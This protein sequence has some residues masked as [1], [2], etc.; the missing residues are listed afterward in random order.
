MSED[1]EVTLE[2]GVKDGT[3]QGVMK[4][5]S[6]RKQKKFD[7]KQRKI[8]KKQTKLDNK[9]GAVKKITKH[10]QKKFDRKQRKIDRKQRKLNK[11]GVRWS[12]LP[13]DVLPEKKYNNFKEFVSYMKDKLYIKN[14]KLRAFVKVACAVLA[15]VIVAGVITSASRASAQKKWLEDTYARLNILNSKINTLVVAL[16]GEPMNE[17]DTEAIQRKLDRIIKLLEEKGSGASNRAQVES[18]LNELEGD[19]VGVS[20]DV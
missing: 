15:V 19:L 5:V 13:A 6:K 20:V 11:K 9:K 10:K 7:R 3:A 14:D 16:G 12:I 17:T 2:I 4:K 8:E 18:Q 1:K